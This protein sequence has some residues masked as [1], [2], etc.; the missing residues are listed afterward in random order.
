[1]TNVHYTSSGTV[2]VAI[3]IAK[4]RNEVQ[5]SLPGKRRR[6]RF[7]ILNQRQ[8]HD[9]LIDYLHRQVG[10]VLIGFEVTGNYHRAIA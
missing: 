5:V 8:D 7:S 4:H 3:D 2:L 6:K 1:M 9:S 10:P